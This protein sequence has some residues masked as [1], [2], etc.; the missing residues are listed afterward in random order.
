[1]VRRIATLAVL[2]S[3]L[4]LLWIGAQTPLQGLVLIL[5]IAAAW[6]RP[7]EAVL[8]A[9]AAVPMIKPALA[10]L[11]LYDGAT[12]ELMVLATVSGGLLRR[13]VS[14]TSGGGWPSWVA[15]SIAFAAIA[16]ASLLVE[17]AAVRVL[18]SPELFWP[19]L[20]GEIAGY[21]S[22]GRAD[23]AGRFSP[24]PAAMAILEGV[25]LFA[26]IVALPGR[27]A[28]VDGVSRDADVDGF[29]RDADLNGFTRDAD[30]DRLSR[31]ADSRGS[32][33]VF[34]MRV[35]RMF[36]LGAGAA[37]ILNIAR[38]AG[39]VLRSESPAQA[40]T[41][42]LR[43]ARISVGFGDVNAAGSLFVLATFTAAGVG[44][45]AR[46]SRRRPSTP[47]SSRP[48]APGPWTLIWLLA[49]CVCAV[50]LWL[51]GSRAAF[52][53][54]IAG[55]I[56]WLAWRGGRVAWRALPA[57]ALAAVIGIWMFPNP[58]V[59]RSA[60]GAMSIRMELARVSFRLLGEAP[61][62]G[63]GIG[64]FYARSGSEIRDPA[65][66]AI[67]PRENAHNNFLQILAELGIVGLVSFAVV[68]GGVALAAVRAL[69]PS[70]PAAGAAI[71]VAAFLITCLAGHPLLTPEVSLSFWAVLGAL[72]AQNTARPAGHWRLLV[73]ATIVLLAAS[74]PFRI[75]H[76]TRT[77][78]LE[79]VAY[80]LPDW[81]HDARGDAFRRMTP[82][83]TLFVPAD[84]TSIEL[85][86]RLVQPGG[87][88]TVEVSFGG[89][90]ADRLLVNDTAWRTFRMTVI[91]GRDD[92]AFL[93]LQL[94]VS[95]GDA[96]LV[97]LGR[98]VVH[99]G[100]PPAR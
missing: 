15:A 67:Y 93:P 19:S 12:A 65:V 33:S 10:M 25:L 1:M 99:R 69:A 7:V 98:L 40:V 5:I 91:R 58:I 6:L 92:A 64:R 30:V 71:G 81:E 70:S 59:D 37:A 84:A 50:A 55:A 63:I 17:L 60:V 20:S 32:R 43:S 52:L 8:V 76:E 80:G 26:A 44:I 72:A 11:G 54:G 22:R 79:R 95:S 47:E 75:A 61:V 77:V 88:V 24:V 23:L 74:M 29:T 2:L 62:F 36:V 87:P 94:S 56:L 45:A 49:T 13:L 41:D 90:S 27:D 82:R 85:P 42:L 46:S 18:L 96:S 3:C 4:L 78:N 34:G 9:V 89:R 28:D 51:S 83:V 21:M 57:V 97:G 39:A 31:D 16:V 100:S 48:L 38:F 86:Y 68:L 66:M 53:A 73:P 35:L 14:W